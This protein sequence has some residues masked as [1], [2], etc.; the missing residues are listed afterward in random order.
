MRNPDCVRLSNASDDRP[1]DI[2]FGYFVEE[3]QQTLWQRGESGAFNMTHY[4]ELL[5]R[6]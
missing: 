6:N 3:N 5:D 2:T 1:R 4:K